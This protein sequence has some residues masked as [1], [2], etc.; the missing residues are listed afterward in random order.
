MTAYNLQKTG[1]TF[2]LLQYA[3]R[4]TACVGGKCY[5]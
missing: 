2:A 1:E 5:H 3:Y 4:Y